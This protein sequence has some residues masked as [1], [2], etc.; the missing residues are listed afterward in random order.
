[1]YP[2]TLTAC[3]IALLLALA[4][5]APR[6]ART[7]T[8]PEPV[9][10]DPVGLDDYTLGEFVEGDAPVEFLA[11]DVAGALAPAQAP[12]D[13]IE[14]PAPEGYALGFD[15]YA[16][17]TQIEAFLRQLEA[18][19][20]NLVEVY[21]IGR[22]WEDRPIM[23]ARVTNEALAGLEGRPMMYTD[24]QHH[25]R[26]L[27]SMEV[28]L[29][30]LWWLVDSYGTDPL[31]SYL[32]DTRISFFVPSVNVDGNLRVLNDNQT[33]R[34]TAN[35]T[36]C[37]DDAD[38]A[39]DEDPPIGFGYGTFNLDRYTFDQEWADA[40]PDDPFAQGWRSHLIGQAERLGAYT[41]ALGGPQLV[42]PRG[43]RDG[44][45]TAWEDPIG[46]TDP[47]R[48]Y[49][50][51]WEQG[52]QDIRAETYRGPAPFS[53][54]ETD[55]VRD[56]VAELDHLAT[57]ISYHSGTDL[58]LH[59]WGYSV[60][61]GLPDEPWFEIMGEKGS[62][63]TEVYGFRGSTHV[64]TA[65]GLYGAFGSTMDWLYGTRGTVAFSPEVYGGSGRALMQRVG[66]T[67][68]Y[69][70]GNAIGF[71]FNPRPED[72]LPSVDRW[73]RFGVYLL[74]ATPNIELNDA[75][76]VDGQLQLTVGN[77][78]LLPVEVTLEVSGAGDAAPMTTTGITLTASSDAWSFPIDGLTPQANRLMA[79]AVSHSGGLA[80]EVEIAEWSFD[81]DPD[82]TVRLTQGELV[83]F[84]D[85]GA[86][87]G[88][89]RA[90]D[91]R[92]RDDGYACARQPC[93]RLAT[94]ELPVPTEGPTQ[95]PRP[96]RVV[97]WP[98]PAPRPTRTPWSIEN[99]PWVEPPATTTP[100][101]PEPTATATT[102]VGVPVG[103]AWLPWANR[104]R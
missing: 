81:L 66:T 73:R 50:F 36:C 5:T 33:W 37:D 26:E 11:P 17:P 68:A 1:M 72:I 93:I 22:S 71:N 40:N 49:D 76:V 90:G 89:W 92:F 12:G 10:F 28:S 20:P 18:D 61:A 42:I 32:V 91:P 62:E 102:P 88:G 4:V 100:G 57:G 27:I 47:N 8:T 15:H 54:P 38:G 7:E 31:A 29:Y 86:Y 53:E 95:T 87:F 55:A 30:T 44:D 77:D 103:R 78:G 25:A 34:K 75:R 6:L 13:P 59:P 82:G 41:G 79:R 35:P 52:D 46:G 48:N 21:E 51:H 69:S 24:S 2:R 23:A 14:L 63:L 101:G 96:P 98:S 45:G 84:V 16:T 70:V 58:I 74:A 67:G 80:H 94:A 3:A 60:E 85:L 39:I 9:R 65:R 43:D 97:A 64:W 56:F 99:P 19:Y 83:P 104:G